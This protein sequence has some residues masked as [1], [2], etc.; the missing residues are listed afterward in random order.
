MVIP[1]GMLWI[2]TGVAIGVI[3]AVVVTLSLDSLLFGVNATDV[4]TTSGTAARAEKV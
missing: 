3:G 2:A 4:M 1:E